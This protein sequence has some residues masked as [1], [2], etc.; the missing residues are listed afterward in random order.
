MRQRFIPY[1]TAFLAQNDDYNNLNRLHGFIYK[2]RK[3][4]SSSSLDI[5]NV[6]GIGYKLSNIN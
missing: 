6:R 3:Y 4:L 5:L 2:L 1:L